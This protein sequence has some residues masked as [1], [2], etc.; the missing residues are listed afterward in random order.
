MIF[1]VKTAAPSE[2]VKPK[3]TTHEDRIKDLLF[4]AVALYIEDHP[5]AKEELYAKLEPQKMEAAS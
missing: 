2:F 1:G 4:Q 3:P 5:E